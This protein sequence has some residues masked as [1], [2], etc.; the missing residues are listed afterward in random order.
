M[1]Y[2]ISYTVHGCVDRKGLSPF[3]RVHEDLPY[4]LVM[5]G[6]KATMYRRTSEWETRPE[7][8][9]KLLLKHVCLQRSGG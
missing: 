8:P 2:A 3:R 4:R 5:L 7:K 1:R 9:K 6:K